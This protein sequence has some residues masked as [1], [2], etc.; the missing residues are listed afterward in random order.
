MVTPASASRHPLNQAV[1]SRSAQNGVAEVVLKAIS[2]AIS[3]KA[4][5]RS[6]DQINKDAARLNKNIYEVICDVERLFTWSELRDIMGKAS[7][8]K[9]AEGI[10][11][12]VHNVTGRYIKTE[13]GYFVWHPT[14]AYLAAKTENLLFSTIAAKTY[15]I[16]KRI[17]DSFSSSAELMLSDDVSNTR[18]DFVKFI[19]DALNTNATDI[20]IFPVGGIYKMRY[21]VLGDLVEIGS[22]AEK[23]GRAMVSTILN[24]AKE[25]TPALK[26][27]EMRRPQDGRIV[28][29][30]DIGG[31]E[32][33]L[34]LSFIPK[35][36]MED[37]DIVIR[38]LKK[39][40]LGNLT[41]EDLGYSDRHCKML[42]TACARSKG[43][44]V[45]SGATGS[46]KS[47]TVN[48]MLSSLSEK[49]NIL[50]IE[51]PIEYGLSNGRQFQIF[52]Y[53]DIET[54]TVV[55][56]GFPEFARAFKRHDPDVIFI[57]EVRDKETVETA[58]HLCKTGHLVFCTMHVARATMIPEV[59]ISDFGIE[60]STV[61]DNLVLGVNQL[62]VKRLC[63][64]SKARPFTGTAPWFRDLRFHN[65]TE[66]TSRLGGKSVY[67]IVGCPKC[68]VIKGQSTI[69][70]GYSGRTLIAEVFEFH[71]KDF[72]DNQHSSFDFDR[73]YAEHGNLLTDA[74][75]KVLTGTID[76]TA[77]KGLL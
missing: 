65:N 47:K 67:S 15:I 9:A 59:L 76:L 72:S 20:H 55:R 63:E 39:E 18:G 37:M 60:V 26:I 7:G 68:T 33:D 16:N 17:F 48:T 70:K 77:V 43:L 14:A 73:R 45:V 51:D 22:F 66:A 75:N 10:T 42:R 29:T 38:L 30:K 58:L 36:N 28:L 49:R 44:I 19:R 46:G 35:P 32:V 11:G 50:T 3:S 21:R 54:R 64:C 41:L 61:A 53:E 27:D 52:E 62:L 24:Y 1:N 34:R 57:G 4:P 69:S 74:I 8:I 12:E 25:Y 5:G 31:A 71:Q 56:T 2:E 6:I 40:I 13:D 23:Y